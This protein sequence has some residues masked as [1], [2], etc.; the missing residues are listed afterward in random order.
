MMNYI[1]RLSKKWLMILSTLIYAHEQVITVGIS[2]ATSIISEHNGVAVFC[3]CCCGHCCTQRTLS[4]W[5][6]LSYVILVDTNNTEGYGTQKLADRR[7][8][9][10]LKW[11]WMRDAEF[12]RRIM[13]MEDPFSSCERTVKQCI[14]FPPMI[15]FHLCLSFGSKH[16]LTN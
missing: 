5:I 1:K 2:V 6:C 10:L 8:L 12:C 3:C 11:V 16:Q 9:I 7:A 14:L 13:G 15:W 4:V